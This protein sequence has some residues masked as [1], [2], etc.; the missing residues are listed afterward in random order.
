VKGR[1]FIVMMVAGVVA[2]FLV[3]AYATEFARATAFIGKLFLNAL[4]MVVLPLIVVSVA[5]AILNMESLKRFTEVGWKTLLY[6]ISTTSLAVVTG[7]A[8]VSVLQPGAGETFTA[9]TAVSQQVTFSLESLVVGLIPSNIF[10]AMV[11]FDVLPVLFGTILFSLAV[12]AV[13]WER[14]ILVRRLLFELDA[15]LMKLTG[16]IIA[17]APLG[18]FSLIAHKTASAGGAKAVSAVLA[19]LGKYVLTV[20]AGLAIHG[21]LTLPLIYFL[22]VRRNPYSY[23]AKVKDALITA[24]ATASSSATLPVTLQNVIGAGVKRPTAEFILPLGATV[25]MDGT[26]LY[27]AVAAIFLAQVYSIHL[28]L[29]QVGVVFITATLA[30]IGAAGIPEAG[31]VTMVLVLKSVGVP[32]EGIGFI[33]AIDWFLD[34]CRTAVNVLGDTVGAA[35][36]S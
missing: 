21:F 3:G 11:D 9:G 27:E 13:E 20:I 23:M 1:K 7:I 29:A 25:N 22:F 31:L 5:N 32:V 15:V 24:F 30:A 2:G 28:S 35:V 8:L 34:R 17:F 18:V 16:W 10:K 6:Y 19:S 26:A 4:K 12:I 33:L 36:V 14:E